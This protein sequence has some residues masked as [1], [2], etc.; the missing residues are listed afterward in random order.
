MQIYIRYLIP[1]R[2]VY[3]HSNSIASNSLWIPDL[4]DPLRLVR[5]QKRTY[6]TIREGTSLSPKTYY[7]SIQERLTSS[8]LEGRRHP[9]STV[10]HIRLY[11]A[12]NNYILGLDSILIH[13]GQV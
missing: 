11:K 6:L 8:P 9:L 10:I 2:K 12:S 1:E 4:E 5:S 13:L 3:L 7:R